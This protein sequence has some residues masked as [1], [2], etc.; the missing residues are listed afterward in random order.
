MSSV[1]HP[2]RPDRP[3]YDLAVAGAGIMGLGCALEAAGRGKRVAVVAPPPSPGAA[4]RAAAG[5]LVTR[6]AQV[7]QSPFREFYVRSIH[8]YPAWLERVGRLAGRTI[9]LHRGGDWMIFDL[10]RAG[11]PDQLE[12]K[13]R[14]W[15]REHARRYTESD[16]LPPFLARFSPLRRVKAFHFPDESYVQNRDL[17][18]ALRA[19]CMARGV[20]FA[21]GTAAGPWDHSG[22]VTRLGIS[23]PGPSATGPAA[24]CLEARQVLVAAGTWSGPLL[25]SLGYEA[26]LIPVKGQLMR[27]PR[28]H[29]EDC[30]VHYGEELYLVPRGD[31]LVVGATTEPGAWGEEFDAEGAGYL[32]EHLKRFLPGLADGSEGPV[33]TWAGLRPRTRDRL[34]WMGW[35]DA[36]RG[37]ALCVGH[38]KCGISMAPL[39]AACLGALLDGEKPPLDLSPFDPWRKKGLAEN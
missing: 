1:S 3:V 30:M 25:E 22:G 5:I 37:W 35:L 36:S 10:D 19:A 11:V 8:L 38:Y 13:R 15:D 34:P 28:F 31:S 24:S 6:D 26:P 29:R 18:D 17:L 21:E 14:Q 7:F 33:E 32:A 27:I 4:S 12:A 23:A 16:A 9:P 20:V 2:T 39:A